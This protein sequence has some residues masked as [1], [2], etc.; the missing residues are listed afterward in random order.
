MK[1]RLL[2]RVPVEEKEDLRPNQSNFGVCFCF[3]AACHQA[4]IRRKIS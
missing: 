3:C 4:I 1:V 2:K